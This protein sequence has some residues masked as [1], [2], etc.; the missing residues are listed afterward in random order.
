MPEPHDPIPL[1]LVLGGRDLTEPRLDPAGRRLAFV[2]KGPAGASVQVVDLDGD[3]LE[4]ILS[5]GPAPSG[6]RGLGGGC[7]AWRPDG[8]AV[9]YA[10]NDGE[11]WEQ[12]LDGRARP[13]TAVRAGEPTETPRSAIAPDWHPDGAALVHQIDDAEIWVQEVDGTARRV[14]TG[15]A[16]CLDPRWSPTGDRVAYQGWDPPDMPW[17]GAAAVVVSGEGEPR[18]R[19]EPTGAAV[20]QPRWGPDGRLGWVDDRSGVL[21]VTIE[22]EPV[23]DGGDR[24]EHAGPTWGPGQ[25]SYAVDPSGT[26][27]AVARNDEGF[28]LLSI[29][30][31]DTGAVT[32]VGRGVHGALSWQGGRLAGLRNGARTPTQIVVYDTDSWTRRIVAVGPSAGWDHWDLPEPERVRADR[33]GV[34]VPGRLYR[35]AG[36]PRGLLCWVH[37]GPTDQWSVSFHPRIAYWESRGWSVLVPDHRGTTG[38][39]RAFQQ[40]LHGGW[41]HVDVEDTVS[42]LRAVQG[43][44]GVGPERCVLVGG[45]A[46]GMT[47]LGVLLDHPDAC[48]GGIAAYPVTDLVELADRSH[49]Y[50]AHYTDTLVAPRRD[51]ATLRARSPLARAAELTRPLQLLHGTDDPVVPVESTILFADHVRG[52]GGDVELHV[53]EGEGHGFRQLAN[54]RAEYE[55]MGSFLDRVVAT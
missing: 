28:G 24:F 11:I 37:G 27:V 16:F 42:L 31:L 34:V 39:G 4:R 13:L 23:I 33:A 7:L 54:R 52:S 36:R 2:A 41:G 50:E 17:D 45:S 6:G 29:V 40:A 18:R 9:A 21:N 15:E 35:A 49:R 46:G 20:Q 8:E 43:A 22:G 44:E 38:H 30:D 53:F 12:H 5:V 1:E 25:A 48:A 26:R 32:D 3:G 47:V 55:L 10:A 19:I 51:E 14:D